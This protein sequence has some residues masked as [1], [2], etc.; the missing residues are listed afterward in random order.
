MV[1]LLDISAVHLINM[2]DNF[3]VLWLADIKDIQKKWGMLR[4]T[5]MRRRKRKATSKS[6]SGAAD[7]EIDDVNSDDGNTV[8]HRLYDLLGPVLKCT[9]VNQ[10]Y[11][12]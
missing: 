6:G 7:D 3:D 1:F 11:G 2:N 12:Q 8:R 9:A 4:T 10:Q 5:Y